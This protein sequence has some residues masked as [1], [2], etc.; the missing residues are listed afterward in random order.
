M[1]LEHVYI[2]KV[3]CEALNLSF[4][5][6]ANQNCLSMPLLVVYISGSLENLKG[7]YTTSIIFCF[8]CPRWIS[9]RCFQT[10]P[11]CFCQA[12]LF[13]SLTIYGLCLFSILS[14]EIRLFQCSKSQKL[15]SLP[16]DRY[17]QTIIWLHDGPF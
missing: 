1:V 12:V 3:W 4:C 13:L 6:P 7:F 2:F 10:R 15:I 16:C 5:L 8:H 11:T 14:R 17:I 9:V